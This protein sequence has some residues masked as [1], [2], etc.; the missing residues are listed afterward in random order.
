MGPHY[1]NPMVLLMDR[2]EACRR[3][4]QWTEFSRLI[5]GVAAR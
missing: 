1:F 2:L 3:D 4:G 5:K